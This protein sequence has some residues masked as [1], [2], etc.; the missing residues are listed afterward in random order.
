MQQHFHTAELAL[1][2]IEDHDSIVAAI[3]DHDA[4]AARAAMQ[5]HLSR[6]AREFQRGVDG[7][8]RGAAPRKA[9][10]PRAPARPRQTRARP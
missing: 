6:V 1:K 5:R 3:A 7:N 9:A 4:D 10:P 8:R 2:T